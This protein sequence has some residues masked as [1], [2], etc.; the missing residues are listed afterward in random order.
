MSN[1]NTEVSSSPK[2]RIPPESGGI[3]INFCKNPNCENFGV[4]AELFG[5]FRGK[6]GKN[7]VT[8]K[9]LVTAGS[10][11]YPQLRCNACEEYFPIKSNLGIAEEV[12]RFQAHFNT[13]LLSCPDVKCSNHQVAVSTPKA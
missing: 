9:Y 2:Y 1:T 3:Q 7:K 4:P 6:S 12:D 13:A 5:D 8:L 10:K 11:G